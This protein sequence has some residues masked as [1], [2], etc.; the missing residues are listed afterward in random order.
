MMRVPG[1]GAIEAA[2]RRHRRA[3]EDLHAA[4]RR[5][6]A[7][8]RAALTRPSTLALAAVAGVALGLRWTRRRPAATAAAVPASGA[9]G[10][11]LGFA[12]RYALQRGANAWLRQAIPRQSAT[13][14]ER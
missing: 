2:E 9:V 13:A 12:L 7:A 11:L 10:M 4:S 14:R 3:V 1:T 8:C 6:V 5:S